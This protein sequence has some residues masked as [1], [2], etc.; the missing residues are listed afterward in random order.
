M[1]WSLSAAFAAAAG[2]LGLGNAMAAP[3]KVP[4]Q[5]SARD[6]GDVVK[7]HRRSYRHPHHSE[8]HHHRAPRI[9]EAPFTYVESGR[10]VVVEAPFTTVYVGRRGRY[11]RAPFVDLWIPR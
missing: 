9:V 3:L 2:V 11:V 7:V 4:Q 5:L 8:R 6:A 1:T 10:R